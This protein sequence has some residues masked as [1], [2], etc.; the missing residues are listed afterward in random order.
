MNMVRVWGGG[1]YLASSFYDEADKLGMLVWQEVSFACAIYP[2]HA[3]FAASVKA[4][5][6]YQTTRLSAHPSLVLWCGNN[7]AEQNKMNAEFWQQYKALA[8]DVVI[9]TLRSQMKLGNAD[10]ALWPSSPSNGFQSSWS[11]PHS[12]SSGD[13]H[14]YVYF[15]D[16][17]DS[18]QYQ[19]P[20]PR[21]QSEFGF[22]SYP[23]EAEL[24]PRSHSTSDLATYSAFNIARQ[25]LNCP[26][27]NFTISGYSGRKTG[28][29]FPMMKTL[30][31]LPRGGWVNQSA[32]TWRHSL[33][34]GQ[35]AQ[36]L[37]VGAQA[38]WLRRGRDTASQTSGSLFWQLNSEWP[39]AS[40][41]SL[42]YD[43]GWKALHHFAERFYAPFS[44]TAWVTNAYQN[45]SFALAN[46]GREALTAS[47]RLEV[48][49]YNETKPMKTSEMPSVTLAAGSGKVV[50]DAVF[51]S[52][53]TH[54]VHVSSSAAL[55]LRAVATASD[56]S[57]SST[58]TPLG[59]NGLAG[60]QG[61]LV[62]SASVTLTVHAN[63][64]VTLLADAVVPHAFLRLRPPVKNAAQMK[65]GAQPQAEGRFSRNALLLLPNEPVM[66]DFLPLSGNPASTLSVAEMRARLTVDC[67]NRVGG[68]EAKS[69]EV[70]A[71]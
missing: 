43:G 53:L 12:P 18:S 54:D 35:I 30:L 55:F 34:A 11:D 6:V 61:F 9:K 42:E 22:P 3:E 41:S 36:A 44:A 56:G 38:E 62:A 13:V 63:L 71:Y 8:Y 45:V 48:W 21:F 29:Q 51:H 40:K 57:V 65:D 23:Q 28:C 66:L 26:L 68:C 2:A 64:S 10:T 69:E 50:L 14:V 59:K 5:I 20:A 37:C 32:T 17:T 15:G 27:S 70:S 25:D 19:S 24:V 39:G 47:W 31:P 4:E 1:Q 67:F 33:Y 58:F 60:A 16:C 46:D 7:E 52:S 49:R